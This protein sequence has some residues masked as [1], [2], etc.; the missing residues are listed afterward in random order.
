MTVARPARFSP[1]MR[2]VHWLTLML[3][4]AAFGTAWTAHSGLAGEWF[5]PV[6]ELHRSLG[7]TV[8]A[9]TVFRLVC[10]VRTLVPELPRD[11]HALQKF[12]ARA[13]EA[14]LYL[15]LLA[16]PVLGF[17][18]TSARGQGVEFYF[19]MHLPPLLGID[20]PLARQ[21][22]DWHALSANLLLLVIGMHSA[23]ALFHHFVR[24]DAVLDAMLP[25]R[26][27]RGGAS[28]VKKSSASA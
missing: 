24:R 2:A 21:L 5:R 4:T 23:A 22:H 20:R 16:Q 6:L 14:L 28:M 3:I 7:L 19:V 9:L 10:R 27:R 15:L 8:L 12:A 11:L 18:Q 26:L 13:T 25:T 17:L 1:T